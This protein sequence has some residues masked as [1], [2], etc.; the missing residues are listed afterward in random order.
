MKVNSVH[1]L[2]VPHV[3]V[4]VLHDL[5]ALRMIAAL[6]L[7]DVS[8][9]YIINLCHFNFFR[10]AMTNVIVLPPAFMTSVGILFRMAMTSVIMPTALTPMR[11]L[12][13]EDQADNVDKQASN[14][15]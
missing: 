13:E 10:K 3:A 15:D 11:M 14:T 9:L 7:V 1:V 2:M 8:L 5:N 6:L 12:V 4:V